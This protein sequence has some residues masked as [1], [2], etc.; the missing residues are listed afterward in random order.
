MN[1]QQ[2]VNRIKEIVTFCITHQGRCWHGWS[3]SKIFKY[4]AHQ[5]LAGTLATVRANSTIAGV[6]IAWPGNASEFIRRDKARE[7][8]F[9][10][11]LYEHGDALMVAEVFG[12]RS[13]CKR[14][15]SEALSRWPH[16]KRVFTYRQKRSDNAPRLVEL[17]RREINRF[18][19]WST[20]ST[21]KGGF[22]GRA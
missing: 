16:V 9:D 11:R 20:I 7:P 13:E 21:Q 22:C 1:D 4:V 10:W 18:C 2:T 15:W 19:G 6:G 5:F 12:V 14:L 3:A 8:Q 17:S